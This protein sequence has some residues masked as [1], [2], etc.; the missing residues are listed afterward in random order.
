M[1]LELRYPVAKELLGIVGLTGHQTCSPLVTRSHWTFPRAWRRWDVEAREEC[2][3]TF[4]L[5][6]AWGPPPPHCLCGWWGSW[7]GAWLGKV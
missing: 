7:L 2:V 5:P 4:P 6:G 1:G 3:L